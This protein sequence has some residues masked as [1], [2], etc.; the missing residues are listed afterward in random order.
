MRGE[1]KWR[2]FLGVAVLAAAADL[3]S[4]HFVF[5]RVR[6]E[7]T[8][9]V[10]VWP[11]R[12]ELLARINTAGIWSVGNGSVHSNTLLAA[13]SAAAVVMMVG[14]AWRVAA[15]E[16][17]VFAVVLGGLA[18]GAAGNLHDRL[19]FGGVRDFL[20]V[21]LLNGYAYPTFNLADCFLVVGAATMFLFLWR[22]DR[23]AVAAPAAS[24]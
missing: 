13:L 5:E 17:W 11:G 20:Q 7:P 19:R 1:G 22:T 23:P 16:S 4:K 12:F 24:A 18:G 14:W 2:C 9:C 15:K 10:E 6:N 3:A 21:Y 8:D